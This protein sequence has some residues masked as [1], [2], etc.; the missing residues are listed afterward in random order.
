MS[1][2]EKPTAEHGLP[3]YDNEAAAPLGI[4]QGDEPP[5]HGMGVGEY[6]ATRFSSLKPPMTKLPNPFSLI[7]QLNRHQWALFMVAFFAWVS[8]VKA[9]LSWPL[10]QIC[11]CRVSQ[12]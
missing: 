11:I 5:H 7:R 4:H 2:H 3:A 1:D 6:I 8:T 10:I 12:G 9:D